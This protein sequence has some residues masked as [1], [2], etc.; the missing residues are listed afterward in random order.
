M[1]RFF[2]RVFDIV[3]SLLGLA[4][5]WPLF[6]IFIVLI[7]IDS[8]GPAI[9]KQTRLGV[10]GK[11]FTMHKFRTMCVDAEKSG[12]YSMK[13]DTRITRM[14]KFLRLGFDEL[15]Q[16]WDILRGEMSFVGPRPVLTYYPWTVD[17]YTPEQ[18][19]MFSVRPGIT[20]WAQVNGRKAVEWEPRIE[21]NVW[22]SEHMSLWLDIKILFMTVFCILKNEGN[23]EMGTYKEH[24]PDEVNK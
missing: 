18:F 22:Y 11:E 21:M 14:G 24:H 13:G 1:Y 17:K 12:V 15:P 8:P 19:K 5:L 6:L 3:F 4:V 10:G 23:E 20:G 2:K 7:R 16:L 9:F